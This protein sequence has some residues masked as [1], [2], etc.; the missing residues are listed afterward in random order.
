MRVLTLYF[1]SGCPACA[2]NEKAWSE[3]SKSVKGR[4]KTK[5]VEQSD[6]PMG[7]Q[8]VSFPT[9]M[10][11]DESGNEMKRIEGTRMSGKEILSE[12]GVSS[13]ARPNTLRRRRNLSRRKLRGRTLRNYVAL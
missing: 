3:A 6:L 2:R 11:E 7:K 10:I 1:L 8:V 13:R 12:L 5:R 4:M 9:M